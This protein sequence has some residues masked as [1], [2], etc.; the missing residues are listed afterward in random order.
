MNI[1][2]LGKGRA[3][4]EARFKIGRIKANKPEAG[5]KFYKVIR[6]AGCKRERWVGLKSDKESLW[7]ARDGKFMVSGKELQRRICNL[8]GAFPENQPH[9][10][11]PTAG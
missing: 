5:A 1:H 9:A 11:D 7:S 6:H 10:L 8:E 4:Q 2:W 3:S